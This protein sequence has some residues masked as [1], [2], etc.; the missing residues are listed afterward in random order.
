MDELVDRR[1]KQRVLR[2]VA[3]ILGVIL[4]LFAAAG[5]WAAIFINAVNRDV[6]AA[7]PAAVK[8]L[9]P[10]RS[11]ADSSAQENQA[12]F[13]MLLLGI[14]K[15]G[16]AG[17]SRTDTILLARIDPAKKRAWLLSLP[18]D[19]R[20][21]IPGHGTGKLNKAYQY[22]GA[23]LTIDTV[24]DLLGVDINHYMEVNVG[25]FR[26]IVA[27]LGGV[28]VNVDTD[29][30]DPKAADS[31]AGPEDYQISAGY[32]KLNP[33]QALVFVRSRDF[34]DADFTRMRHQ[35]QF[36]RAVLKQSTKFS[37]VFKLPGLVR[38]T[39]RHVKTDLSVNGLIG[40][41]RSMRGM[42]DDK[43]DT[44]TLAGE[45]HSPYV[46]TDEKLKADLLYRMMHGRSFEDST[47]GRGGGADGR[48]GGGQER[49]RGARRGDPE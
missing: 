27:L 44:A 12:P 34:P 4:V 25:G 33:Q 31:K 28:W 46:Y 29:I 15:R 30:D 18:R 19:T 47:R 38:E 10:V 20:A 49:K 45:W 40:L 21:E 14:D 39:A 17:D 26:R 16:T 23:A 5:L 32:Q 41:A 13:N 11:A 7:D 48:V 35:Q 2:T 8:A 36:F 3:V 22:G 37:N 9:S 6:S 24:E 1:R 42:Q 43:L